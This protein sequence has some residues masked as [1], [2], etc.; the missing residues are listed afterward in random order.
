M[1]LPPAGR[2]AAPSAPGAI[3]RAR[4]DPEDLLGGR[5]GLLLAIRPATGELLLRVDRRERPGPVPFGSLVKPF[6]LLAWSR[7]HGASELPLA[8]CAPGGP[9]ACWYPQGHGQ[10][11]AEAALAWSCNAW[12][13]ELAGGLH[14][15]RLEEVLRDHGLP[16]FPPGGRILELAVGLDERHRAEPARLL[17]GFVAMVTGRL[18]RSGPRVGTFVGVRER[19]AWV[20][21]L[22]HRGLAGAGL[23]GTARQAGKALGGRRLLAKTGTAARISAEGVELP[24]GTSGWFCGLVGSGSEAVAA[25]VRMD[26]GTGS[27]D[28]APIGGALLARLLGRESRPLPGT[29]AQNR[30]SVERATTRAR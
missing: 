19:A 5:S 3:A 21:G 22:L 23:E 6:T 28:A 12:F 18:V 14:P 11:D 25:L 29:P 1:S 8:Y 7:D 9:P 20:E 4:P 10:V 30:A 2:G 24:D 27:L 15:G 16:G 17:D 26:Q 13:R